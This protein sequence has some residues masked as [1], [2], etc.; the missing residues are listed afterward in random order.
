M[1]QPRLSEHAMQ[2]LFAQGRSHAEGAASG[3]EG[4]HGQAPER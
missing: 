2:G 1:W 3:V 4:I